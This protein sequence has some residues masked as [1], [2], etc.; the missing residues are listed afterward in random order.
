M[1]IAGIILAFLFGWARGGSLRKLADL[2]VRQVYLLIFP[3]L[4][5]FVHSQLLLRAEWMTPLLSFGMTILQYLLIFLFVLLNSHLW[6]VLVYG[7]G[8]AMN[9]FVITANAGAMPITDKVLNLGGSSAKFAALAE[10]KYYTYEII[11][12]STRIPFLGDV[13]L[14]PGILPQCVSIG[15]IILMIGL[16]CLVVKGMGKREQT[17]DEK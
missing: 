10:G 9:F 16:F 1:L 3:L 15:D 6:Q 5:E 12:E 2:P 14:I 4:M 13:I 11:K 7:V 17:E 8:S